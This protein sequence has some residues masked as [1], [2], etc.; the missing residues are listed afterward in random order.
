[1][2]TISCNTFFSVPAGS[3]NNTIYATEATISI[4]SHPY[5]YSSD[6]TDSLLKNYF[7]KPRYLRWQDIFS[8]DVKE[9]SPDYYYSSIDSELTVI[10]FIVRSIKSKN[11]KMSYNGCYCVYKETTLIQKSHSYS[12]LP[13]KNNCDILIQLISSSGNLS[14]SHSQ[15]PPSLENAFHELIACI[16][17]FLQKGK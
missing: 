17:P 1:M 12:Y 16:L 7:S 14:Y 10:Y 2:L 8:V 5:V 9:Y 15:C 13:K 6:F 3:I 11:L 4:I